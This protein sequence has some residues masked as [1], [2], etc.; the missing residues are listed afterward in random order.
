MNREAQIASMLIIGFAVTFFGWALV[1]I[2]SPPIHPNED[3]RRATPSRFR[4]WL[5]ARWDQLLKA[6]E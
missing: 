1:H 6:G 2:A 3:D 5:D 4:R